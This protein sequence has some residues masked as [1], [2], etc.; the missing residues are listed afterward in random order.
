MKSADIRNRRLTERER[1]TLRRVARRQAVGDDSHID[2]TDIPRLRS[3]QLAQMTRFRDRR[4]KV[5]VSVRLDSAVLDWL[6]SNMPLEVPPMGCV[7]VQIFLL[8][9]D[10]QPVIK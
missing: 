7:D 2:V 9:I 10:S 6:K 4:S 8:K 5:A 1:Q 3:D